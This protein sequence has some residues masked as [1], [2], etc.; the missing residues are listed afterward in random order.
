[1]SIKED[2]RLTRKL[3][4]VDQNKITQDAVPGSGKGNT[5]KERIG[6]EIKSRILKPDTQK[7]SSLTLQ[8][9]GEGKGNKREDGSNQLT[10]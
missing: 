4:E 9:P 1:M 5:F 3:I 7:E 2:S 6:K 10:Q 8:D